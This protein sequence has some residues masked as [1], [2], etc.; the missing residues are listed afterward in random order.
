MFKFYFRRENNLPYHSWKVANLKLGMQ[1][2]MT[3]DT[4]KSQNNLCRKGP[5]MVTQSN[6][7]LRGG[8]TGLGCPELCLVKFWISSMTESL[9]TLWANSFSV[10]PPSKEK[11]KQNDQ[12]KNKNPL[13]L[14]NKNFQSSTLIMFVLHYPCTIL[15][16]DL[17]SVLCDPSRDSWR[18]Q[19]GSSLM[20][21][22]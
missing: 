6:L 9:Q 18:Q 10:W 7:Q 12:R 13:T 11:T 2:Q 4:T 1:I 5:L 17:F 20:F 3:T 15:R 14:C 16:R 8:T 19:H 21:S 22:S